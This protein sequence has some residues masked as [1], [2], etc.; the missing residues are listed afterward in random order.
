MPSPIMHITMGY[1]V[2]KNVEPDSSKSRF[3]KLR[4]VPILLLISIV[5]SMFPDLDSIF[6]VLT[7]DFGRYHNNATHSLFVGLL[8]SILFAGGISVLF[9]TLTFRTV[10]LVTL[11]SYLAHIVFDYFTISR[12]VMALWPLSQE[13]F[14]SPFSLFY[15]FH[16]SDGFFSIR[17]LWTFLTE[18][19]QALILVLMVNHLTLRKFRR[20][21]LGKESGIVTG[22]GEEF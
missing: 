12:G 17:H 11:L 16:W 18:S 2:Y 20:G 8:V 15:G 3:G 6:G 22:Q 1:V 9:K 19:V 5:A 10:F 4:G 7:G 13:R 21:D 14:V